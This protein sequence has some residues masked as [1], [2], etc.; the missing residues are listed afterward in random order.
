[1]RTQTIFVAA[2]GLAVAGFGILKVVKIGQ[3]PDG[4][5][6]IPTGQYLTPAGKHVEINDRPLGLTLSPNGTTVA[7]VTGSNFAPRAL[8][9]IDV[10]SS[11]LL[12]SEPLK[13]SFAGVAFSKDGSAIYIGGGES[14]EVKILRKG[15]DGRFAADSSIALPDSAPSGLALSSDGATLL[16]ALNKKHS[17]AIIDISTKAVR[18]VEVGNYP[19]TAAITADGR[20]A[21]VTNWAGR[22]PKGTDTADE[23]FRIVLDPRTGIPSSGSVSVIDV[24]AGRV[25]TEIEVGLHPSGL[26]LH[27]ASNRLYVA[28]ANSD[29]V[30]IVNTKTDRI[31]GVI[32]VRPFKMAPL[33]SSPNALAVTRDGKTLYVANAANNAVAVVDT[34]KR[35]MK[36]LIPTGWY[37]TAVGLSRDEKQLFIASGYGFGSIAATK[38]GKSGRS[39][40]DRAGIVSIVD[41][42]APPQLAAWTKEVLR[43]N[44]SAGEWTTKPT[45]PQHPVPM[46]T[47]QASPIKHVFYVMK[48]NRTYDQ[49]FGDLKQANGDPSLVQFGRDV[50]PNHHAL[51]EQF[52]ILDNFFAPGDQ[53][54]LGHRWCTQGY[55]S[56]W[57]HKYS[58][59]RNDTNPMLYAP[60]DFLW[61]NAKAHSVSVRSYGERGFVTFTP[62]KVSWT[63]VYE[64]WKNKTNKIQ[65]AA[66]TPVL[67]LR[68][69]YST[70]YPGFHLGIPDQVR[71][72]RFLEDF[73]EFEKNGNLP[74]LTVL[75]L[76]ADHTDGTA[77]GFPTPRAMVADNDLAL[78]R[79]VDAISK[80][81][82]WKDSAIFV[83]EDDA[84]NGL[85]HVDGHRTIALAI[86]PWVKRKAVD[87]TFYTTINLFRTIEQILGLPPANQFDLAAEPM[88]TVFASQADAT[89]Y[90]ALPNQIPLNEMNPPAKAL[91]G[92]QRELAE[93][94]IKMDFDE[95]DAAP[96]DLLNRAIWHSVKGFGTPYPQPRRK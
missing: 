57:V 32:N 72:D 53:S 64:D 10:Q 34:N 45:S 59:G 54:A 33:G 56:D 39:Y 28:N 16:V 89:P 81:R 40:R 15:A 60:S 96:E 84:Q 17:A 14:H 73:R 9:I 63:D 29:S 42:P 51:A 83:V 74:R 50:T 11:K 79:L 75:L 3:Q 47:G 61:D 94:S 20:K 86:G 67:G 12:Q 48:E 35:E 58:N 36:G 46:S 23:T 65:I 52:V 25:L 49:L 70:R 2:I 43:N 68:D 90:T 6:L 1:M 37:P 92:L 69:I 8:H 85:D 91:R 19:Y 22:R 80:S 95:P 66:R 71:V 18:T 41:T 88:F 5:F 13:D 31:S 62:P 24:V 26:A 76:P 38:G 55:A 87:S 4:S 21:Y 44:N 78:G 77:P 93:A 82:Y 30:T 27:S 7:V